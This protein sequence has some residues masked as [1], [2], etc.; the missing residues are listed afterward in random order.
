MDYQNIDELRA[1]IEFKTLKDVTINTKIFNSLKQTI[2]EDEQ[3]VKA[4]EEL[5]KY[6][7]D[8]ENQQSYSE[9]ILRI[10]LDSKAL[11]YT[12]IDMFDIMDKIHS[13]GLDENVNIQ[14]NDDNANH[15]V[16][17]ILIKKMDKQDYEIMEIL[18]KV[19]IDFLNKIQLKGLENISKVFVNEEYKEE[20]WTK[21][22]WVRKDHPILETE[23][24]NLKDALN[25][26]GVDHTKTISNDILEV[27][28]VLGIEATRQ[29]LLNELRNV[30]SFDGSYVNYRHL[31]LLADTMTY[32]GFIMAITRHGINR[33]TD[34]STLMKCSFEET[35]DVL[36]ESAVYSQLDVIKGV[37]ENIMLGQLAPVGTGSFKLLLDSDSLRKNIKHSEKIEEEDD[38]EEID[39]GVLMEITGHGNF[40]TPSE[41]GYCQKMTWYIP[42]EP[43][44]AMIMV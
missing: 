5:E 34:I 13:T 22:G 40:Y 43:S 15:L 18:R 29:V 28:D 30:I 8:E 42:S 16:I 14:M 17:R 4:Y 24:T 27:Y 10:E 9:W 31:S 11:E 26:L 21:E 44:Y 23:G 3:F 36:T 2:E 37:S 20:I 39:E 7:S 35:V 6:I 32:K 41:P 33:I 1:K 12:K 19:E 25:L 38:E